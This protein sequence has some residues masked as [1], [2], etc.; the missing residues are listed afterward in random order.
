M[1]WYLKKKTKFN[2][3]KIYTMRNA[4][5]TTNRPNKKT[6]TNKLYTKTQSYIYKLRSKVCAMYI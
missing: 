6:I 2:I 3:F 5:P 4:R 1:N